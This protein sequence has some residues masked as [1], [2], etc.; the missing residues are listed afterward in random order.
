MKAVQNR[1]NF[2]YFIWGIFF[3]IGSSLSYHTPLTVWL[4]QRLLLDLTLINIA[5]QHWALERHPAVR[6]KSCCGTWSVTCPPIKT[7]KVC[8]CR[9][10]W[11][12]GGAGTFSLRVM[13]K[14][15]WWK[16]LDGD[17]VWWKESEGNVVI[18]ALASRYLIRS[19]SWNIICQTA[20]SPCFLLP[21]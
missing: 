19:L 9:W 8:L 13:G 12:V 3:S 5:K 20:S 15:D 6:A 21:R 1:L 11:D 17:V 10:K 4:A 16:D 18:S 14:L 7:S 2:F